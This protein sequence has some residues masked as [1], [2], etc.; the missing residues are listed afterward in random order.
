FS[1][2]ERGALEHEYQ[3]ARLPESERASLGFALG[4][5]LEA[6]AR[7]PEAFTSF[8]GANAL[9]RRTLRWNRA[10][11]TSYCDQVL[12]AFP[13]KAADASTSDLGEG[14]IFVIGLPDS[15]ASN[16]AR[17]LRAHPDIGTN[18]AIDPARILAVESK[19][20]GRKFQEWAAQAT[21]ADWQRLGRATIEAMRSQGSASHRLLDAT[22]FS[23][24]LAG[25]VAAMLP[26]VRFIAIGNDP[27]DTC[28]SC[29]KSDYTTG[30]AYS[31]DFAELAACW[32]DH[33]RLVQRWL[34][35]MPERIHR[36][37]AVDVRAD[38]TASIERML[39]HCGLASTDATRQ[40]AHALETHDRVAASA[41]GDLLK[42]LA[43]MVKA[44]SAPRPEIG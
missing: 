16:V 34:E 23:T 7:Y 2:A 1:A 39:A 33:Q 20:R 31:Y 37:D 4:N 24:A 35:R 3:R 15:F 44:A 5:V 28:W 10:R 22:A 6:R 40:I 38:A 14:L 27:L 29:F 25:A 8:V 43:Q 26:R 12:E 36:V 9:C 42:P 11:Y 30:H 18:T 13:A 19:R 41:Y 32:H 21:P 17:I